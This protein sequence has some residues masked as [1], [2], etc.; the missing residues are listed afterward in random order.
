[1]KEVKVTIIRYSVASHEFELTD[2]EYEDFLDPF[3]E[4]ELGLIAKTA[5]LINN[6]PMEYTNSDYM[7]EVDGE[8]CESF[9]DGFLE[10]IKCD[11]EERL[12]H[13]STHN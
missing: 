3:G 11:V 2:D 12:N 7:L 5:E 6:G 8:L 13:E 9:C 10:E 1:M 4:M